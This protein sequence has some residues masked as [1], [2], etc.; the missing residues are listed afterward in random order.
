[1]PAKPQRSFVLVS[2][3]ALRASYES[4]ESGG[5]QP[6]AFPRLEALKAEARVDA[7][8]YSAAT[9][10]LP[11]HMSLFTGMH[12][13]QHGYGLDFRV[14][15]SYPLPEHLMYLPSYLQRQSMETYGFHNGGIME[16]DRGLGLGWTRY[17]G[18]PPGDV[19]GPVKDF[20]E[21]LPHLRAPFFAFI[22]TYAVHNYWGESD[23]PM[24]H[25]FLTTDEIRRVRDLTGRWRNLR[26]LMAESVVGK[27]QADADAVNLIRRVY[28]GAVRRFDELLSLLLDALSGSEFSESCDLLVT[29]DHGEALGEMHGGVQ[30]WSHMT[31]NVH[32][33]NILVPFIL[34]SPVAP[35]LPPGGPLSLVDVPNLVAACT[36]LAQAF[37]QRPS[38]AVFATGATDQFGAHWEKTLSAEARV[39]R[40]ALITG[41]RKY[42]FRGDDFGLEKT[43]DLGSD[44]WETTDLGGAT[45]TSEERHLLKQFTLPVKMPAQDRADFA[46]DI[47]A[48]LK[49]LG[50]VD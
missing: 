29:S 47:A 33:E 1:M 22:H 45:M 50:Y 42:V 4:L 24:R 48:Q 46:D 23:T 25:D 36:G 10:T 14:G 41:G 7:T 19:E 32:E 12:P 8:A 38:D 16:P 13:H 31:V 5:S 43:Y 20:I 26:W 18:S 40:S 27:H 35:A 11:S 34:K 37:P 3:D 49:G 15:R 9:W 17:V 2:A 21:A 39:Y 28:L 30:H 6:A 44:P